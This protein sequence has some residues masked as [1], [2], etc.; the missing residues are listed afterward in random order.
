MNT[1]QIDYIL[2]LAQ[3]LN[4]NKAAKNLF[5][6][7]PTLTYQIKSVEDEIGFKIFERS[8]RGAVLSAAGVQFCAQLRKIR[9]DL[10]NAI[11][12][13]KNISERY[14][15][16]ITI[17]MPCR[18][19]LVF[20]PE[21]LMKFYAAKPSVLVEPQFVPDE[22]TR[23][24]G[25]MGGRIDI[26]FALEE[27]VNR[28]IDITVY[29]LYECHVFVMVKKND[30][31]ARK[32]LVTAD[33]LKGRTLMI[34]DKMPLALQKVHRNLVRNVRLEYIYGVGQDP[35][36]TNVA[37]ERGICITLGMFVNDGRDEFAY[38][39]FDCAEKARC[40]LCTHINERRESVR[41]L[42]E[43]LREAQ[44]NDVEFKF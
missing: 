36:L 14:S 15:E 23:L 39:P 3:T 18:S 5:I 26:M 6:S 44:Q 12:Q 42:V 32:E 10:D 28:N 20:L 4:F 38:I 17:C 19:A 24:D 8:G 11:G 34:G 37:A 41:H 30:P 25:F 40:V 22:M 29:P 7:Q 31:L 43:L 13:G 35:L 2:E 21:V 16:S 27:E 9:M 1:K 33:D